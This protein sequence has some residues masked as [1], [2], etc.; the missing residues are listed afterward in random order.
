MFHQPTEEM[1]FPF[2]KTL[3]KFHLNKADLVLLSLREAKNNN[4][5]D[6]NMVRNE[7]NV[8]CFCCH[9]TYFVANMHGKGELICLGVFEA[10]CTTL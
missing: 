10:C 9:C 3:Q 4:N 8:F 5:N 2:R 1:M 6:V 7:N